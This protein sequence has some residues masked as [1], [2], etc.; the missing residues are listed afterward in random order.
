VVRLADWEKPMKK[1]VTMARI[2]TLEGHDHLDRILS[3]LREEE[4]IVGVTVVRG[5]AGYGDSREVHSANLLTLSLELPLTIEFYDDSEKVLQAI[6]KLQNQ[7]NLDHIVSW[8]V[9]L[10]IK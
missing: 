4:N 7:L 5:I 8:P 2:F 3:I 1:T 9:S 10:H 6:E